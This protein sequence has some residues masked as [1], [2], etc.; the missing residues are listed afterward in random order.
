MSDCFDWSDLSDSSDCPIKTR[1]SPLP[2]YLWKPPP[3]PTNASIKQDPE[4]FIVEEVP[5]FV[6]G[7]V[8]HRGR[9]AVKVEQ[10]LGARSSD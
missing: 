3:L 5:L 2:H 10:V 7:F 6:G 1:R 8:T 9:N 4:D